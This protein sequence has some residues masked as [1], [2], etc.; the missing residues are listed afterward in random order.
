MYNP[1]IQNIVVAAILWLIRTGCGGYEN[2]LQHVVP[3]D[4]GFTDLRGALVYNIHELKVSIL[5]RQGE[6]L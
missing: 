4:A 2:I 3:K 6:K 1:V 5:Y